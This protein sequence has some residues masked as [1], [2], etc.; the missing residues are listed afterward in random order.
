[1]SKAAV[2]PERTCVSCRKKGEKGELIRLVNAPERVMI[3]YNEKLPGRGAYICPE[4]ACIE[5]ALKGG[6]LSKA[7]REGA[8]VPGSEDFYADLKEK[9]LKKI[10]SLLGMARKSGKIAM[11]F[12]PVI[13]AARKEPGGLL[14]LAEDLSGNTKDKL[15]EMNKNAA[16]RAFTLFTKESLGEM[17]GTMPVGLVYLARRD[18][19]AAIEKEITRFLNISRG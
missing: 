18:F 19:S 14:I 17:L 3:D 6:L 16:E 10:K 12:D 7:F 13:E 5:K 15:K 2:K 4:R 8:R 1:M 9:N 11:G